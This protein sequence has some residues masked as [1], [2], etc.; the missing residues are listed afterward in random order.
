GFLEVDRVGRAQEFVRIPPTINERPTNFR[1][2]RDHLLDGSV[3]IFDSTKLGPAHPRQ[4]IE[5][6]DA[7]RIMLESLQKPF[8]GVLTSV[9]ATVALAEQIFQFTKLD[10]CVSASEIGGSTV[11]TAFQVALG[12]P[13]SLQLEREIGALALQFRVASVMPEGFFVDQ[14]DALAIL[15]FR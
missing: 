2:L 4:S 1:V 14:K 11:Q 13:V 15:A 9:Q 5:A 8:L 3:C 10:S 12:V 7:G 6:V